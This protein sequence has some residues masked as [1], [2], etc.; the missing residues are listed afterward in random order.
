MV[1][2]P[3]ICFDEWILK[4]SVPL[5]DG[6]SI[7]ATLLRCTWCGKRAIA[8][9]FCTRG[10]GNDDG[11]QAVSLLGKGHRLWICEMYKLPKR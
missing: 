4:W 10:Q 3:G 7:R 5:L 6:D 1:R 11:W 2:Q 9:F 8:R